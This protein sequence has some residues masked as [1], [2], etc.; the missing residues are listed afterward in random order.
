MTCHTHGLSVGILIRPARPQR[1]GVVNV[2]LGTPT[3]V[4]FP[5]LA[6]GDRSPLRL[7]EVAPSRRQPGVPILALTRLF[8]LL[9]CI[10]KL[11]SSLGQLNSEQ[12]LQAGDAIKQQL[13]FTL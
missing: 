12:L 1:D 7:G 2:V 13:I 9:F 5:P 11:L 6:D 4:A 3:H 8:K 10:G